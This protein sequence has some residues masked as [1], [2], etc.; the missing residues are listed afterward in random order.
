MPGKQSLQISP[1][2]SDPRL[3]LEQTRFNYL[4]GQIEKLRKAQ[5]E[6]EAVILKFRTDHSRTLQPLRASL[7]AACRESVFAI[8][9]LLDQPKWSR[10]DRAA[11]REMLCGT[12][13]ALLEA[14]DDE[15][16][17]AVFDK[18]SSVDFDAARQAELQQ[19]KAEAEKET[20]LDLGDDE[21]I[22]S[23]E[24][25]VQ[26]I[27]E[28][29]AAREAAAEEI[30]DNRAERRRK[31]ATQK[32]VEDAARLAKESLRELYRRLASA[33]HPDRESDPQRRAEKNAL[34]Q[35][36]NQAYAANDLLTL[37]ETQMRLEK[38]DANQLGKLGAQRL[39]QYNKLLTEQ[40]ATLASKVRDLEEG[41]CMDHGMQPG[42][43]LT[44]HN[45]NMLTRRQARLV[46]AEID[47]QKKFL[48]VLADK[49]ALKRWLKQQR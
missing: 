8:D 41:F 11:L 23:E 48:E 47:Q 14:S 37:F 3:T 35:T 42:S 7:T 10:V 30:R 25:L 29:M 5:T 45:L 18:H 32:R 40:L 20:G 2:A 24:D 17:K 38:M 15:E 13:S 36:I 44:H 22:R 39:R 31:S 27:Y 49:A 33:V 28:E 4:I 19:L 6:V 26:R 12:A 1:T 34:M 46:R 9:R 16:L 43:G 21:S